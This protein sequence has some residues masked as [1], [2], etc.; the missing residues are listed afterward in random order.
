ML[1]LFSGTIQSFVLSST[2]R[3]LALFLNVLRYSPKLRTTLVGFSINS[4]AKRIEIIQAQLS[5]FQGSTLKLL[6]G[7]SGYSIFDNNYLFIICVFGIFGVAILQISHYLL[8]ISGARNLRQANEKQQT[9]LASM[10]SI[11]SLI[12]TVIGITG[13]PSRHVRTI[14]F[15]YPMILVLTTLIER[16]KGTN[17][18]QGDI[19]RMRSKSPC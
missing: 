1:F 14:Y 16:D 12:I 15:I 9:L 5:G 19:L 8:L 18:A 7:F 6:F 11:L 3:L 10:Y 4:L 17:A 13:E 2:S